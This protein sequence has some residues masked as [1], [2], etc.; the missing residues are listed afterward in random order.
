MNSSAALWSGSHLIPANQYHSSVLYRFRQFLR[1]LCCSLLASCASSPSTETDI[2]G[3]YEADLSALQD[4]NLR[5]RLNIRSESRSDTININWLQEREQ[6]D[7]SL[8]GTLGLG[9]VRLSGT[10]G[11]VLFEKNG[12]DPVRANSLEAV[13]TAMLGYAFPASELLYWVRGIPSP[14][15]P[16]SVNRDENGLISTLIQEDA[17]G[18]EWSLAIDRYTVVE[19]L[20]VPGRIRLEQPPFRLTLLIN[21]WELP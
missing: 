3:N 6:F 1:V 15:R 14:V 4:W 21:Q 7:I 19:G 18:L 5:G 11:D 9:A 8:S 13:T 16:S 12:D 17:S 10:P 2:P 20:P